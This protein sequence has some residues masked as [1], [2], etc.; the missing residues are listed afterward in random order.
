MNKMQTLHQFWSGFGL[1]AYEENSVP[2]MVNDGN[3]NMVKLVPP[4]IT[5]EVADDDFG[6]TLALTAS[7]WYRSSSRAEITEKTQEISDFIG[8]GGRQFKFDTGMMWIAKGKPFAQPD[9]DSS[10]EMIKIMRLN[11]QLEFFS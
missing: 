11:I 3:G 6:N 10:D 9:S 7:L 1:R 5:Y 4:Y 2:E 8:R